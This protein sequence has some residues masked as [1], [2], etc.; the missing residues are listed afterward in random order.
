MNTEKWKDH[1]R[2][3]GGWKSE[4]AAVPRGVPSS[5]DTF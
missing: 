1:G 2:G 3:G 5:F 4:V